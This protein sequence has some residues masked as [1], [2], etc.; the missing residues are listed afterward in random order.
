MVQR[1]DIVVDEIYG[2]IIRNRLNDG[3]EYSR[4]FIQFTKGFLEKGKVIG[5]ILKN[6]YPKQWDT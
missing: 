6:K 3:Y 5:S 2:E 1:Q 4:K